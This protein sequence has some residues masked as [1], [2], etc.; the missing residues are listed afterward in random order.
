MNTSC[1]AQ[2]RTN[3]PCLRRDCIGSD[4]KTWK[5]CRREHDNFRWIAF[6]DASY[7]NNRLIDKYPA[8]FLSLSFSLALS[9]HLS[10]CLFS[11]AREWCRYINKMTG[12]MMQA[13]PNTTGIDRLQMCCEQE[14][15]FW[16]REAFLLSLSLSLSQRVPCSR[17]RFNRWRRR[18]R[19]W[20]WCC[21]TVG[22]AR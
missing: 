9:I 4:P 18:C 13:K 3:P 14:Y 2:E 16:W 1:R 12:W 17:S 15:K 11:Y 19:C 6:V 22:L 7:L 8:C 20:C 10:G 21:D 5:W